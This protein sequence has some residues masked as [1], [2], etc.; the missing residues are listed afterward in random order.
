MSYKLVRSGV[1][2]L[3]PILP[4]FGHYLYQTNNNGSVLTTELF[5]EAV[6]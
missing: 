2:Q 6:M 1:E 5:K 4:K 3:I